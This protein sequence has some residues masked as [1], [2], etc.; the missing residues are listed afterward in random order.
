[1]RS[2]AP[3][4]MLLRSNALAASALAVAMV[5]RPLMSTSVVS[6]PKPRRSAN[7]VP[8]P[9]KEPGFRFGCC[10]TYR[11]R[12]VTVEAPDA[13]MSSRSKTLAGISRSR[14]SKTLSKIR[15]PSTVILQSNA[16]G[17][18]AD[19]LLPPPFSMLRRCSSD[20]SRALLILPGNRLL[21]TAG[22]RI[23]PAAT[24]SRSFGIDPF[25]R[26]ACRQ[27]LCEHFAG[28]EAALDRADQR[29]LLF[30]VGWQV[31]VLQVLSAAKTP[32]A[33]RQRQFADI[34]VVLSRSS[35]ELASEPASTT[36]CRR[37]RR[38]GMP[39]RQIACA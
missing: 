20:S 19:P 29:S 30:F 16:Y 38:Q 35:P 10:V 11:N 26:E 37:T 4:G 8:S 5:R 23:R 25:E 27:E 24:R 15:S 9:K 32:E 17:P 3:S 22:W 28:R 34:D 2:T 1:M 13:S 14:L 12:S 21:H 18:R 7:W 33:P 6:N 39:L 31:A 36:K